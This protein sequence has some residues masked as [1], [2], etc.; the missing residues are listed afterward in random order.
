MISLNACNR[1]STATG[2]IIQKSSLKWQC[3]I[4][5]KYLYFNVL[6]FNWVNLTVPGRMPHVK[7]ELLTLSK[8][9]CLHPVFSGVRSLVFC[10]VFC[11]SLVVNLSFFCWPLCCMSSANSRLLI[12][13]L[14]S[15][16]LSYNRSLQE[17]HKAS[18]CVRTN[19]TFSF[20]IR[21]DHSFIASS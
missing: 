2:L 3:R 14:V 19:T 11:T 10:V 7:Q 12:S 17:Y 18:V 4:I 1:R 9:L 5:R 15:S 8:I 21:S 20:V 6:L 13:P 16:N